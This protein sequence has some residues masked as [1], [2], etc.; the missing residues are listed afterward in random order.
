MSDIVKSPGRRS[1]YYSASND[2]LG[3][4]LNELQRLASAKPKK[5]RKKGKYYKYA[6]P[7]IDDPGEEAI[8]E[9]TDAQVKCE[10]VE[11][12]KR[13]CAALRRA[14]EKGLEQAPLPPLEN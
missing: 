11:Q 2:H 8:W 10:F 5:K 3:V 1:R 9:I 12:D 14:V 13:F 4:A 7:R 6:K